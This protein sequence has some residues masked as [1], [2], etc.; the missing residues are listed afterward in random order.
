MGAEVVLG[1]EVALNR[2]NFVASSE[3]VMKLRL[4][5]KGPEI[6]QSTR[7]RKN[8]ILIPEMLIFHVL[9]IWHLVVTRAK[10]SENL[11]ATSDFLWLT[12]P[13]M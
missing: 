6:F 2:A 5:E 11:P 13:S 4:S 12:T 9:R 8:N 1:V 3:E 7:R 10:K